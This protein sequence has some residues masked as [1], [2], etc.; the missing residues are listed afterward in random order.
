[1][2]QA[3]KDSDRSTY[4]GR[5]IATI[6][7]RIVAHG[8]TH[9][10][11]LQAAQISRHKEIPKVKYVPL[12]QPMK[13]S[14]IIT[15]VRES[16]PESEKAYLVGGAVRDAMLS[17]PIRDYDFLLSSDVFHT[18]RRI[19][20]KIGGAYYVLD[21]ERGAA[22]V[23]YRDSMGE[24]YFLDFVIKQD[25]DLEADLIARDFTINA[26]AVDLE[27][28]QQLLDPLSGAADLWK[29][30]IRACSPTALKDD[31]IRVIRAVRIA[32]GFGFHIH[33][34]TRGLMAEAAEMMNEVSPERIRDELFRVL[35]GPKPHTSIRA[36]DILGV[37]KTILPEL[38][39]LKSITQS[40]PH[41]KD[42]FG[43]TLDTLKY[44][45]SLLNFIKLRYQQDQATNLIAG[46][47][48]LHLGKFRQQI[49]E[50]IQKDLLPDRSVRSL[51]F[52][53]ALYHDIGKSK[54]VRLGDDQRIHF[55]GHESVGA[56]IVAKRAVELRLSKKEVNRLRVS[57][58]HHMRPTYLAREQVKPNPVAIYQYFRST[59]VAGI[60]ICLISLADLLATY[61][62]TLPQERWSRQLEIVKTLME[63][64]WNNPGKLIN[65]PVLLTGH[66]VIESFE[67]NPG[68][69]VGELLEKLREAQVSGEVN[70]QKEAFRYISELLGR[71]KAGCVP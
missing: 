40:P 57:V 19:A 54:T 59:G 61:G 15:L 26:M 62:V 63:A 49:R 68:P 58:K 6:H 21:E 37:I 22:R 47:F 51:L 34:K 64:W 35:E 65:P 67:L 1:M 2:S 3:A 16:L 60:D 17:R 12:D 46:I 56:D 8:G 38:S 71:S 70:N 5:W 13:F 43:H 23:I 31:P 41:I 55:I 36:L 50:H 66:D 44:L 32:A 24:R 30:T 53:A 20:D 10:Q 39:A 29:K 27:E 25:A 42:V 33:R 11:A 45:E 9:K 69:Q 4:K 48:Q 28:P 7:G 52:M 14:N 18:A